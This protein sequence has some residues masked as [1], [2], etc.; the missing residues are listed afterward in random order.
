MYEIRNY[1]LNYRR[2]I[3]D[4]F[5]VAYTFAVTTCRDRTTRMISQRK[6]F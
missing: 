5:C 4:H 1:I 6:M 3:Y 2:F